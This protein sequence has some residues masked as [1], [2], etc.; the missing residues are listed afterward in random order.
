MCPR[1]PTPLLLEACAIS[2]KPHP[3]VAISSVVHATATTFLR[4]IVLIRQ[5]P[6]RDCVEAGKWVLL[7][8]ASD[9]GSQYL[10]ASS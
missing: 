5:F 7:G 10:H 3:A 2:T 8:I 6:I 1:T 9:K 4:L